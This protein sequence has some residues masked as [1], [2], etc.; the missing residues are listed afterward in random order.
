MICKFAG[1]HWAEAQRT[2][3]V[4]DMV[5]AIDGEYFHTV[6]EQKKRAAALE[7]ELQR[8]YGVLEESKKS[9]EA[10]VR[11]L[12]DHLKAAAHEITEANQRLLA[13]ETN[14]KGLNEALEAAERGA[15]AAARECEVLHRAVLSV[16][17]TGSRVRRSLAARASEIRDSFL[18]TR[19]DLRRSKKSLRAKELDTG[20]IAVEYKR[21]LEETEGEYRNLSDQ[22][23][24]L[25]KKV[26]SLSKKLVS[27]R[28]AAERSARMMGRSFGRRR[29]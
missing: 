11:S 8:A 10:Q 9:S 23:E 17:E 15:A 27:A 28:D 13:S 25:E 7:E 26:T 16:S 6:D 20:R 12:E 5:M 24:Q 18:R 21:R 19:C 22:K 4:I 3:W 29:R 1:P 2:K 14:V